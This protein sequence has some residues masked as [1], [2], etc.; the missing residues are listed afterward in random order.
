MLGLERCYSY[1]KCRLEGDEAY[2]LF[3]ETAEAL[4]ASG[5][6]ETISVYPEAFVPIVKMI[7]K[8][9]LVS[10]DISFNTVQGVRAADYIEKV[11]LTLFI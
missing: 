6:A 3:Q 8:D 7:D 4:K 2:S 5:M 10:I 9:T 11:G 1:F